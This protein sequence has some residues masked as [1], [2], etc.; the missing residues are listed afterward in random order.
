VA[1][2]LISL[3][4]LVLMMSAT[5][6]DPD[7]S[8]IERWPTRSTLSVLDFA[9]VVDKVDFKRTKTIRIASEKI[10]KDLYR[11]VHHVTYTEVS[12]KTIEVIVVNNVSS[13]ECS[14]NDVEVFVVSKHLGGSK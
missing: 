12:G 9:G 7:C 11:Q 5:A 1:R 10:G 13:E 8:G 4:L 14:M 2:L 3:F 6:K